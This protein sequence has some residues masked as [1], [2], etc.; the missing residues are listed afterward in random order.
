MYKLISKSAFVIIRS[1]EGHNKI[2]V[3]LKFHLSIKRKKIMEIDSQMY[4]CTY[5]KNSSIENLL[6]KIGYKYITIKTS[7]PNISFMYKKCVL[8]LEKLSN[9]IVLGLSDHDWLHALAQRNGDIERVFCIVRVFH[10]LHERSCSADDVAFVFSVDLA[11]PGQQSRSTVR[12]LANPLTT[13]AVM[14]HSSASR[15]LWPTSH[16]NS[17][18]QCMCPWHDKKNT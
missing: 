7:F 13:V 14:F 1:A 8:W 12:R 6:F 3:S 18:S 17:V 2:L 10:G 5:K 11:H 9:I 16:R 15:L 4:S